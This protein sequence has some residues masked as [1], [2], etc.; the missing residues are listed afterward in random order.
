MLVA[1][2]ARTDHGGEK[3]IF[4]QLII[5]ILESLICTFCEMPASEAPQLTECK[6]Q[7]ST[8]A[9]IMHE[10]R[11]LETIK[12]KLCKMNHYYSNVPDIIHRQLHREIASSIIN[13]AGRK[14]LNNMMK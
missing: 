9:S 3:S 5:S 4:N 13:G 11:T 7:H 10:L 6:C 12:N 14:I 2:A 8:Q 1:F